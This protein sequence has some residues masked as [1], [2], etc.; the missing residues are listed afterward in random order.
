M[1][2]PIEDKI[3]LLASRKELYHRKYGAKTFA[4]FGSFVRGEQTS[5]SDLD[6]LVEFDRPI[7]LAF[8]TLADELE[9]LLG[10]KVD[11]VSKRAVHPRMMTLIE[12]ELI[13]V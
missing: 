13:Y 3:K 6:I 9:E 8:V 12:Q 11:L 7:G 2:K 4:F 5:S 10:V 1:T